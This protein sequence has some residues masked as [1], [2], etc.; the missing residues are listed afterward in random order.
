MPHSSG[1]FLINLCI[2]GSA[3]T[4]VTFSGKHC[5]S[6]IEKNFGNSPLCKRILTTWTTCMLQVSK[7]MFTK[8]TVCLIMSQFFPI[9]YIGLQQMNNANVYDSMTDISAVTLI[10]YSAI[11]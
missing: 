8:L 7:Y 11:T 1:N 5:Y 4:S 6:M 3:W 9:T 2:I 10:V